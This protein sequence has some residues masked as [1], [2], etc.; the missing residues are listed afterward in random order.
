MTK[1]QVA[2]DAL[3]RIEVPGGWIYR[4]WMDCPGGTVVFSSVFV[5]APAE[6]TAAHDQAISAAATSPETQPSAPASSAPPVTAAVIRAGE[7]PKEYTKVLCD[8]WIARWGAGSAPGDV[9]ASNARVLKKEGAAWDAVER[10]FRRYVETVEDQFASPVYWRKRW[11][12]Y[13][14]ET[15]EFDAESARIADSYDRQA[16]QRSRGG[17]EPVGHVLKRL[18]EGRR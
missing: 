7:W 5:P 13:D 16:R 10:S 4:T 12:S 11:S 6:M 14:P 3:D 1:W 15:P 2:G 9:I 18:P 17:M 8:I